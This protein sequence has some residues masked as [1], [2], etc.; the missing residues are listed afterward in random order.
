MNVGEVLEMLDHWRSSI[1]SVGFNL[2]LPPNQLP[3]EGG[4]PIHRQES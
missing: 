4:T 3:K 2:I 1:N